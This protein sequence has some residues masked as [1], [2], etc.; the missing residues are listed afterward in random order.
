MQ[1]GRASHA[2]QLNQ[3]REQ[4][5]SV[6]PSVSRLAALKKELPATDQVAIT[7]TLETTARLSGDINNAILRASNGNA[8]LSVDK[9][10][11][12]LI[13]AILAD[14]SALAHEADAAAD[15]VKARAKAERTGVRTVSG[16]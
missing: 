14:S 6:L 7:K 2:H 4:F 3:L 8:L 1:I 16:E 5:N 15:F 13:L 10:Y 11:N 9:Q 12:E